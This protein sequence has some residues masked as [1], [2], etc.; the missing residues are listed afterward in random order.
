MSHA[1][2]ILIA[3]CDEL[4]R[5]IG[6]VKQ[7]DPATPATR[8]APL[9]DRIL[10]TRHAIYTADKSLPTNTNKSKTKP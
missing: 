6:E 3:C 10:D 2:T 4:M 7:K 8:W 9:L 1:A 5:H